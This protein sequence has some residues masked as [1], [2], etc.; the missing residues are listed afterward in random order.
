MI[1]GILA[2]M[3]VLALSARAFAP[4]PFAADARQAG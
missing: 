1:R 2:T 4:R 3:S